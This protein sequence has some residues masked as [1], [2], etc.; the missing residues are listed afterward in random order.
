MTMHNKKQPMW[1][2]SAIRK[3]EHTRLRGCCQ[4]A[5]SWAPGRFSQQHDLE[6][7]I[8]PKFLYRIYADYFYN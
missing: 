6:S 8:T 4:W 1:M 3:V 7:A 2:V 5:I